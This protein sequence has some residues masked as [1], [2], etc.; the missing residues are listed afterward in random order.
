MQ[1]NLDD[2]L[3]KS[4]KEICRQSEI[5]DDAENIEFVFNYLLNYAIAEISSIHINIINRPS[6]PQHELHQQEATTCRKI[7]CTP[8]P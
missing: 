6:A 8:K 4:L 7:I 3:V 5:N 1:I 2:R